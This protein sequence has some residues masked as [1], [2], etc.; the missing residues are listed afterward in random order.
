[1]KQKLAQR[2]K[3]SKQISGVAKKYSIKIKIKNRKNNK[4]KNE[5]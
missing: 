5:I 4:V 1:M 2:Q 3:T